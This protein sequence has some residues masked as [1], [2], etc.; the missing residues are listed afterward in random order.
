MRAR[1]CRAERAAIA[2]RCAPRRSR[3]ES[4]TLPELLLSFASRAFFGRDVRLVGDPPTLSKS[5]GFARW[6][7]DL[8]DSLSR[9]ELR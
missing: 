9:G 7:D 6:R 8:L 4:R 3:T 5:I 1:R 2:V